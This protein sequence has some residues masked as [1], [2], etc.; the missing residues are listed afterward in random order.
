MSEVNCPFP[1]QKETQTQGESQIQGTFWKNP[2]K[3]KGRHFLSPSK[4]QTRINLKKHSLPPSEKQ[5]WT[6]DDKVKELVG[7]NIPKQQAM[8][9]G[10][11]EVFNEINQDS[12]FEIV[13]NE[14]LL[15]L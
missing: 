9:V 2:R 1:S 5:L 7:Y 6:F 10:Y 13:S 8:S 14:T 3:S 4:D 11:E 12:N 15:R